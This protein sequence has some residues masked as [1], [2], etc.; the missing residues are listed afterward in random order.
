LGVTCSGTAVVPSAV[1]LASG[2]A[3][4][5]AV[6]SKA[7]SL[8]GF[9]PPPQP[10]SQVEDSVTSADLRST[11]S[12]L[13]IFGISERDGASEGFEMPIEPPMRLRAGKRL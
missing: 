9:S 4:D 8:E 5:S 6:G 2:W 13:L 12:S 3:A 1:G 11:R 10:S 7:V